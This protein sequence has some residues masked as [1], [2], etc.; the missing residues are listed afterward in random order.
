M[1]LYRKLKSARH[2]KTAW[3]PTS[4]ENK[5]FQQHSNFIIDYKVN[6]LS[7]F[8]HKLWIG[9]TIS[10]YFFFLY[11]YYYSA[12][13]QGTVGITTLTE[14]TYSAEFLYV[15]L[16]V[17]IFWLPNMNNIWIAMEVINDITYVYLNI[18]STGGFMSN[19]SMSLATLW[20]VMSVN[21]V[22]GVFTK[23][24]SQSNSRHSRVVR[25][26]FQ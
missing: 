3:L 23:V 2:T 25:V 9:V 5:E 14:T 11:R 1:L 15:A 13:S 12:F 4:F 22:A 26:S 16:N 8:G 6:S 21:S 7:S 20:S 24:K 18:I 10:P 19:K 17:H